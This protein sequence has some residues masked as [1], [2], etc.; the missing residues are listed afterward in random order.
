MQTKQKYG[1]LDKFRV[2]A[3]FLVIAIHTS[4]LESLSAGADFFLTRVLARI[5]VP[6]FLMVTGQFAAALF[7]DSSDKGAEVLLKYLKK[8][9]LLYLFCMILYLPIGIYAGHYAGMTFGSLLR[10]LLFDGTFYHLWYFPACMLGMTLVYL[11]SRFMNLRA[12]TAVSAVL[13]VIGLFG[14]SYFGL[15]QK[16]PLLETVYEFG[17]RIFSYTRNGLFLAPLFLVLGI[18][19]ARWAAGREAASGESA[20][21]KK[22]EAAEQP[23]GDA[24]AVPESGIWGTVICC[25]GLAVSFA[26]MTAEAF[27]LRYFELQRHDSMYF[28]LVPTMI[29]LYICL[30]KIPSAPGKL[31]RTTA[32]WIYVLH[33]AMIVAVRGIGKIFHVTEYIVNNQ[34]VHYLLVLQFSLIAGVLMVYIQYCVLAP[35]LQSCDIRLWAEEK[36]RSMRERSG[37]KREEPDGTEAEEAQRSGKDAP[38]SAKVLAARSPETEKRLV[39][40]ADKTQPD[41]VT[42]LEEEGRTAESEA[43]SKA[44]MRKRSEDALGT[45]AGRMSDEASKPGAGRI[46]ESEEAAD[47]KKRKTTAPEEIAEPEMSETKGA[48]ESEQTAEEEFGEEIW[49]AAKPVFPEIEPDEEI[50]ARELAAEE[51]RVLREQER[52]PID[53]QKITLPQK[54]AG[55]RAP[56]RGGNPKKIQPQKPAVS[57]KASLSEFSASQSDFRAWIE[58]DSA[59]LAG[60]VEFLRSRIPE[61]C[62]LMPAVKAE[63]YGHGAVIIARQ[64]NRLNVNAFC[65]ACLSEGLTLRKAGVKGKILILGYTSPDDFPLLGRY[66]LT[67]AVIDYHYAQALN[68]YGK[69]IHVHIAIDTGM[70]RLGIRCENMEEITSV[71]KMKNLIIDGLFT[72]LSASDSL[73]PEDLNFTKGQVQAF[74]Q[75]VDILRSQGYPCRGLHLLASYGILNLLTSKERSRKYSRRAADGRGIFNNAELAGD[76]VRP[77]IALYGVLETETD[78][79]LWRDHLKPVLSLKAKVVSVRNLYA[80]EAAGYGLAFTAKHDMK[81]ATLSIGYADGVPREL[82]YGI[83]SVLINGASA[84][85]IGRICM[86]QTLVDVSNIPR[87]QPGCVAVLIGKSGSLEITAGRV[88]DQCG[89]IT[90][91]ILSRLGARLNRVIV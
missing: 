28:A 35:F 49:K 52:K 84:P 86:D 62:R 5:A 8:T 90:N 39:L 60:N 21:P 48:G 30:M 80:G 45:E 47:M 44:E 27:I 14:D 11:M 20:A 2:A 42:A 6:F 7:V 1:G 41:T 89:T 72:H 78:S 81:I 56:R 73:R 18:W 61:S 79:I 4:P 46:L 9:A 91:E 43:A 68:R 82:S 67:Q 63:A 54:A 29:F 10:M 36:I 83:G 85:I 64:L 25:A 26:V 69:P 38:H 76:Y 19:M 40:P 53:L 74:Y 87:I 55:A 77:G 15:V 65:V 23:G 70:H 59:A 31:F 50:I 58:V 22:N 24:A 51:E 33:P 12:M 13:Y 32:M 3:A 71:Y 88:A 34:L 37:R 75:V 66:L 16:A 57:N 17:F